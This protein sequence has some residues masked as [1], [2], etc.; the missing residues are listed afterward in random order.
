MKRVTVVASEVLGMPGI[1]GPGTAD[2]LLA[3]ALARAGHRV[4]VLVAPGREVTPISPEWE[5]RYADANVTLRRLEPV[6]VR[7]DFLAPA[8]AV[9]AGLRADPPDVVVAD[10][11]RGLA[12]AVLRSR[13]V[14]RGFADTAFV[15]YA[16]GPSRLLAEAARKVPDT[17]ARFGEEVAQRACIELADAVVSPSAWL[18]DWLREHRWPAPKSAQVIQNLWQSVALDEPAAAA[19]PS[20]SVQRLAFFGQ[21]REGK[22]IGIFVESLRAL[23]PTLLDGKELLFLGRESKRWTVERIREALGPD[24]AG[25]A[26]FETGLDRSGA[27]AELRKPGTL[28]VLPTLLEN[29]PYAVAESIEHAIPFVA[30]D[31]GGLRELVAEA[32]A[33]RVLTAPTTAAFTQA[34]ARALADGVAPARSAR[35]P[36]DAR[37]AWLQLVETIEPPR[38][39]RTA[40]VDEADWVVVSG[41]NDKVDDGMMD[42]LASAQASSGADV[43]TTAVRPADDPETVHMFLGAPGALGLVENHYGVVGLA[44]RSLVS[45]PEAAWPLFARLALA[46]A[47]IVSIP[48]P[49][50]THSGGMGHVAD[51]PGEGLAVL[52]AFERHAHEL[53]DLPQL[54]A[55]LA[56]AQGSPESAK[57]VSGVGRLRGLGRRLLP[58]KQASDDLRPPLHVMH[59]GKTGG[60]ALNHVLVEHHEATQYKLMFGGHEVTLAD[61]PRGERFMFFIRDPLTRFVS[62]FNGRLR[63]DRPRYHYS[64]NEEERRAFAVFKTPDQL[65]SALSSDDSELRRQAEDAMHGIGHLNTGYSFWFGSADALRERSDDLFFIGF[66][67]R[68]DDDFELLKQKLGL[69]REAEL[70]RGD[71]AHQAPAEYDAKLGE[72]AR[73]NLERWYEQDIVFVALCRELAALVNAA[74]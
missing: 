3:L 7:P 36:A 13:Q 12:W 66:Q 51:V 22:G 70:P 11:W 67:D 58:R 40:R 63:E 49:L 64:W 31:V 39:V 43:V 50:A 21:L 44:R 27:L 72:G 56:A 37:E 32:D 26:R 60:T 24:L 15:V 73:A 47:R 23:D 8:A 45:E 5:Q 74:P 10:D 16:H 34:L 28:V 30:A 69:P 33:D 38:P 29:S 46:G 35:A 65:G 42:A 71:A 55:T 53:P 52:E 19:P 61:I 57:E 41:P 25:R 1:G 18:L 14:G 6:S 17:I 59:I 20:S 4:D 2:S 68:L 48:D 9:L 54:A 62:A